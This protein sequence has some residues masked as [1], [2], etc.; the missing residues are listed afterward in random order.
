MRRPSAVLLAAV[1]FAVLAPAAPVPP[2][3]KNPVYY[4]PTTVGAKWEYDGGQV[5][6]VSKVEDRKG[7]AVVTVEQVVGD[8]RSPWEVLEASPTGLVKTGCIGEQL[9][10]SSVLVKLPI[11]AGDN[12]AFDSPGSARI[13]AI[14]GTRTVKGVE[15]ITV[16]A[17]TFEAVRVDTEYTLNPATNAQTDSSR[18]WYAPGVGLVKLTDTGTGRVIWLLKSFTPGKK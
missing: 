14:K 3:A 7:T 1:L 15:K 10:Q 16:P 2:Q 18:A 17:G 11:R 13:A 5:F 8:R 6:V 12:W 4:A 9:P